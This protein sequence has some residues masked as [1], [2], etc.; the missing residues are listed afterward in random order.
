MERTSRVFVQ[1]PYY[2][3]SQWNLLCGEVQVY[4]VEL[5]VPN[6]RLP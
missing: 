4:V 6:Q 3:L 5:G 1:T 2:I